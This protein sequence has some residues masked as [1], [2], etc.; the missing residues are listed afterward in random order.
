VIKPKQLLQFLFV[1]SSAFIAPWF[2]IAADTASTVNMAYGDQIIL[3]NSSPIDIVIS[4]INWALGILALIA[5]LIILW[6]GFTWLL[7]NGAEEKV[8]KAKAIIKN[9]VIGLVIILAS[10]GI[11]TYIINKLLDVTDA[12]STQDTSGTGPGTSTGAG[13][14]LKI[15][16]TNPSGNINDPANQNVPLCYGVAITFSDQVITKTI[17]NDTPDVVSDDNIKVTVVGGSG[18]PL[19]GKFSFS[20]DNPAVVVFRPNEDYLPN[21]DYHV[22]I[23]TG[24]TGVAGVNDQQLQIYLANSSNHTNFTFHTGTETD[25]IPP[26]V[27][28]VDVNPYPEDDAVEICLN[29]TIQVSFSESLDPTTPSDA[30]IWLY[31]AAEGVTPTDQLD[32]SNIKSSSIGG[33]ADDTVVTGVQNQLEPK[34][35]YGISLY[36]GKDG[37]KNN[38]AITDMCGNPLDGN[39]NGTAQ[40][41]VA[42]D[43]VDSPTSAANKQAFCYCN[44][45]SGESCHVKDGENSCTT[46][47]GNP[48][49]ASCSAASPDY[50][51]YNYPWTWTTGT[52]P[53][54]MPKITGIS[55]AEK[56]YYSENISSD[57]VTITGEYLYPFVDVVFYRNV[58]AGSGIN[59]FNDAHDVEEKCY[60]DHQGSEQIFIRTAVASQ[61]EG[62]TVQNANGEDTSTPI[63]ILSPYIRYTSPSEGPVGQY[64]TIKGK[65]FGDE[66]GKVYFDDVEAAVVCD[67]SW[68]DRQIIV[69]VP[70]GLAITTPNIQVVTKAT[71]Y[72]NPQ[73]FTVNTKKPGPGLC[74]LEPACSDTGKDDVVGTGEN[75]GSSK[76][77]VWFQGINTMDNYVS[78][79]VQQ[80]ANTQFKTTGTPVVNPDTYDVVAMDANKISSNGLDF[81][82]SCNPPPE[83]YE[84]YACNDSTVYLPNPRSNQTSVCVNAVVYF[85]FNAR[86]N[87]NLVTSNTKIYKCN[88]AGANSEKSFDDDSCKDVVGGNYSIG[89]LS[90]TYPNYHETTNTGTSYSAYKFKPASNLAANTYYKVVIPATVTNLAGQPM[91]ADYS[92]KFQV[93]DNA[94]ACEA[95]DLLLE[96]DYE[97]VTKYDPLHTCLLNYSVDSSQYTFE[98]SPL[99]S[100]CSLLNNTSSNSSWKYNWNIANSDGVAD[101]NVIAFSANQT[102][103][104]TTDIGYN[105]VCLQGQNSSNM[106]M[107]TVTTDLVQKNSTV[108]DTA[109]V[110]VD[111]GYCTNDTDCYTQSCQQTTCDPA[112]HHCTP[113]I[114]GFSPDTA[115]K[116]GCLTVN[117]CYFGPDRSAEPYCS[118]ASQSKPDKTCSVSVGGTKCLLNDHSTYCSLDEQ[119]CVLPNKETCSS[120]SATVQYSDSEQYSG[121]IT[122]CTCTL[123]NQTCSVSAGETSCII[124]GQQKCDDKN[125]NYV[126]PAVGSVTFNSNSVTTEAEYPNPDSCQDVWDNNQIVVKVPESNDFSAGSYGITVNS[127]YQDMNGN[128]LTGSS[129]TNCE[130][131]N[132]KTA[133]LC[134]AKPSTTQEGS[135]TDLAGENFNLL[136]NN[137]QE[138]VT[139]AVKDASGKVTSR[140]SSVN[141]G[142]QI[143]K[144]TDTLIQA[145]KIPAYSTGDSSFGVRVENNQSGQSTA[146]SNALAFAV[147]CGYKNDCASK[148]CLGGQCVPTEQCNICASDADC[149]NGACKSTCNNGFCKPVVTKLSPTQGAIGQ[150]VTVQGCYFGSYYDSA[151][152]VTV[153]SEVEGVDDIIA[154]LACAEQA[155]NNERIIINIPDKTFTDDNDTKA[156]LLVTQ[157]STNSSGQVVTQVSDIVEAA[158]FTKD[159]SCSEVSMPILCDINPEYGAYTSNNTASNTTLTGYYFYGEKGGYCPC[160]TSDKKSCNIAEGQTNCAVTPDTYTIPEPCSPQTV[161]SNDSNAVY[162]AST[163]VCDYYAG[164]GSGTVLCSIPEGASACMPADAITSCTIDPA[165]QATTPNYVKLS[166]SVVF[167]NNIQAVINDYIPGVMPAYN[168]NIP[169]SAESGNVVAVSTTTANQQCTS[170]GL[171]FAVACNTCADCGENTSMNCNFTYHPGNAS[172]PNNPTFGACTTTTTGFCRETL[173][174]GYNSCCNHTSCVYDDA[175]TKELNNYDVGT[176]AL[177][178]QILSSASMPVPQTTNVCSNAN[179]SIK[180]NLPVTTSAAFGTEAANTPDLKNYVTLTKVATGEDFTNAVTLSEDGTSITVLQKSLLEFNTQYQLT[181][182]ASGKVEPGTNHQGG[183]VSLADGVAIGCGAEGVTCTGDKLTYTFT[184]VPDQTAFTN[185]CAPS[186]V[187]L[188]AKNSK[189]IDAGYTFTK[190]GQKEAM[191]AVVYSAGADKASTTDDQLVTPI[192]GVYNWTY[193]WKEKYATLENLDENEC[194]A[195]GIIEGGNFNE[196]QAQQTVTAGKKDGGSD[197]VSVTINADAAN[198]DGWTGSLTATSPMLW[199]KF[200]SSTDQLTIYENNDYNFRWS[201]C[202]DGD[203]PDFIEVFSRATQDQA[204]TQYQETV[205]FLYEA[206]F[207]DATA[208][209]SDNDPNANN[210]IIALRVYPNSLTNASNYK[211]SVNPDLWY[212]LFANTTETPRSINPIDGYRAVQVNNTYYIAATNLVENGTAGVITPYIYVLSYSSNANNATTAAVQAI[213]DGLDFN[214]NTS[215]SL[216]CQV[217]KQ[218]LIRDTA[219]IND[220]GSMA[221]LLHQYYETNNDYPQLESGSYIT[222][223]T[224][225]VWPSWAANLG[226]ALGQTLPVDSVNTFN[227]AAKECLYKPPDL[228]DSTVNPNATDPTTGDYIYSYYDESGTC[229]DPVFKDYKGP[230]E[231]HVYQYIYDTTQRNFNLYA[232]LEYTNIGSWKEELND[233]CAPWAQSYSKSGCKTFNY[234]VDKSLTTSADYGTVGQ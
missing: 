8:E 148:C 145:V 66:V 183:V 27:D 120:N 179:I 190:A 5:V 227:N 206:A 214:T 20:V 193:S 150:P 70:E 53:Y 68:T 4:V 158:V 56:N 32:I 231:S 194:P 146:T 141:D 139:F 230:A 220:F 10:W 24:T 105:T 7:S 223:L 49:N 138:A 59:C 19:P 124:P 80:W 226:N 62:V 88:N 12:T 142:K 69:Q 182:L 65:Q 117:G 72:S 187:T 172:D 212:S 177:Q 128:N 127:Y 2:V 73:M 156:D 83:V 130:I 6:G 221:Y 87:D 63:E 85:A 18:D 31:Q 101:T 186:R 50:V 126:A 46:K 30:N 157:A 140:N 111:Y 58:L 79:L 197:T 52:E 75:F 55:P 16:H 71:K 125:T 93:K 77:S 205:P 41:S 200:C 100:D 216:E 1:S 103:S 131:G 201:Y 173:T 54:C 45:P 180:F 162:N 121:V 222:N 189:F 119:L 217:E 92:W 9:G 159:N 135:T 115:G 102:S 91:A 11:V 178:P 25:K 113:D 153:Y 191:K 210:N 218:K 144:W 134:S 37:N 67:N 228:S 42:D 110:D 94:E 28:V 211:D 38:D 151:S 185:N 132:E 14:Q 22:E 143:F 213:L 26:V 81:K 95:S 78:A 170:N 109:V 108:T 51:A 76:G 233:P 152:Q 209:K 165:C 96:P 60:V 171:D 188:E 155:W 167:N 232:N 104:S 184:T 114:T 43:F 149:N 57:V 133:C 164:D 196:N 175:T 98:A 112:S 34:T 40:G 106:G 61:T 33:F 86:M 118:C 225:S 168:T 82:I 89:T 224:T 160:T 203:L 15:D 198:D 13:A 123:A 163:G 99:T 202:R 199:V 44:L 74:K 234:H 23:K 35:T 136:K 166:G 64:V 169:S 36:G 84:Y 207:K 107:R 174:A 29:P 129:D 215:L 116:G 48:C 137:E 181:L 90:T 21:T 3:G 97:K 39:Y 195:L 154:D 47:A 176:C 122:G 229:W 147:S 17:N 219:R 192:T 161:D 204:A 208:L